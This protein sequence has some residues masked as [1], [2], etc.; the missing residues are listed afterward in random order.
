MKVDY[1]PEEEAIF[2]TPSFLS[3]STNDNTFSSPSTE[4]L[5]S[6]H[7]Q[8][9]QPS[10]KMQAIILGL[11]ELRGREG[12]VSIVYTSGANTPGCL[13]KV[14]RSYR[15]LHKQHLTLLIGHC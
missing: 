2:S 8:G 1:D 7:K 15:G 6:H 12:W 14:D 10:I 4:F 13:S 3:W 11:I 9:N 5:T